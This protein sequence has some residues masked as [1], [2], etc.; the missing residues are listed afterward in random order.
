M[1]KMHMQFKN[2]RDGLV[3][4]TGAFLQSYPWRGPEEKQVEA[5]SAWAKMAADVYKFMPPIVRVDGP[6][7][8]FDDE[9]LLPDVLFDIPE[10][11]IVLNKPRVLQTFYGFRLAMQN[12]LPYY[13]RTFQ[14]L[15][16][17]DSASTNEE[18]L[19]WDA[20]AWACSL[21]YMVSP[22]R[23]RKLVRMKAVWGVDERDLMLRPPPLRRM[24]RA[25]R[26]EH[27]QVLMANGHLE[28][29][30]DGDPD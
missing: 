23:F 25:E 12:S 15:Q 16:W 26:E 13:E 17:T 18:M 7:E 24:T 27:S 3:R 11:A 28:V 5:L 6:N 22:K 9:D 29:E 19:M 30:P 2:F 4:E 14:H 20:Q 10:H 21:Y 1:A 8:G